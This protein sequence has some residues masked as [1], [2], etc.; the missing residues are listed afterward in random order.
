MCLVLMAS[1]LN[2]LSDNRQQ[3]TDNRWQLSC[4]LLPVVLLSIIFPLFPSSS[5]LHAQTEP[6]DSAYLAQVDSLIQA[7][8]AMRQQQQIERLVKQVEEARLKKE[9]SFSTDGLLAI[10][11][12]GL[13]TWTD[14]N[15]VEKQAQF[16]PYGDGCNWAGYAVGGVPLVANWALKAA[17]VK[18]RSKLERM[19]TANAMALGLS[20]GT[21]E[22]LKRSVHETRP[23]L[24]DRR[25]FPSGHASFAFA[26]AS[27]LS[28][29]YGYLSPWITVGS[30]ATATGTQLMRMKHNKHWMNDLYMGAGIGTVST[31]LAYFLT[32]LIF[33]ADAINKPEVRRKDVLR[34][35]KFN[36][37][38]SGL[39]FIMGTE[40]GNRKFRFDDA[41]L[42]TG[43]S[44]STGVDVAW[45]TSPYFAVEV[46]SRVVNAQVKVFGQENLFTG[47][48]LEVYH[49]DVAAKLSAPF[50]LG[51]RMGIRAFAGTRLMDGVR[52]T[53]GHTTY[54]IPNETKFELGCGINYD[55]ID[56]DN[57]A[58]G[59]TADYYHTFSHYMRNRYSISSMVKV[60]F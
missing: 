43:A 17:G 49:F 51:K 25:A 12:G 24:S 57:Y 29:E 55:C 10:A 59:F 1:S 23:D 39:S 58:W 3:M 31:S 54:S 32:D 30:Y 5:A 48:H 52:L 46:M 2:K 60:L 15:F 56:T 36:A 20:F 27:I 11:R 33:G 13:L 50:D 53:D 34:L 38:P 44:F 21:T 9:M 28:R 14:H 4:R 18:S 19:L 45:Y 41:T 40:I 37:Q 47:G 42:K 6:V 8:E 22:I 16:K 35:M 7:Y 26:S